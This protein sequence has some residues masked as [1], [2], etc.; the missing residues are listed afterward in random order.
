MTEKK[1]QTM[2]LSDDELAFIK[3]S[4]SDN[5]DLLKSIRSLMYGNELSDTQKTD[6]VKCFSYPG[7]VDIIR[8]IFL[9]E[10]SNNVP[11]GQ[12][13]DLY[14]NVDL[15]GKDSSQAIDLIY[16]RNLLIEKINNALKLLT[17]PDLFKPSTDLV[18]NVKS[19]VDI[20]EFISR[21]QYISQVDFSL[22][23]IKLLA[24][25]KVETVEETKK[26][27]SQNSSK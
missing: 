8:K 22:I 11:I 26:R 13:A 3:D 19:D 6:I 20:S 23:Q 10:V 7:S 21:N 17:N 14:L 18:F 15:S 4:F 24:G 16:A 25:L 1:P 12:V 5:D 9:P 2:R 27:L